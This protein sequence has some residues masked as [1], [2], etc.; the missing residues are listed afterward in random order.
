MISY[1]K[2]NYKIVNSKDTRGSI[3]NQK[4]NT[5]KLI[6]FSDTVFNVL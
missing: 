4:D 1:Y 3:F 6:S 2:S 5:N